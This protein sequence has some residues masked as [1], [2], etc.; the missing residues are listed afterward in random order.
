MLSTF[1][2]LFDG[3]NLLMIF[4]GIYHSFV[5]R[6]LLEEQVSK[7]RNQFLTSLLFGMNLSGVVLGLNELDSILFLTL[8]LSFVLIVLI[9]CNGVAVL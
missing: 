6:D 4:F 3:F 7:K 5:V 9:L 2:D 1:F 8:Q